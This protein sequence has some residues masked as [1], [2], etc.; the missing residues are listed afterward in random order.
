LAALFFTK[1]NFTEFM[2]D[3]I[4]NGPNASQLSPE[5]KEKAVKFWAGPAGKLI[6]YAGPFIGVIVVIA[7]GAGLYLLGTIALGGA[8]NYKQALAVWVYSSF[9]PAVLSGIVGVLVLLLKSADSIDPKHPEAIAQTNLGILLNP[10]TSPALYAVLSSLD[11]FRFYGLF[12]A[13][14]GLKKVGRLST[15][16]AWTVVLALFILSVIFSVGKAALMGR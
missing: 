3:Q 11:L 4:E 10:S 2:R 5:Q 1:I 14:I 8:M 7:A 13:A 6:V 15:G 9:P 12:L 16:S